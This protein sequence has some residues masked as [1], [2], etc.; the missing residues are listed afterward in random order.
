MV[1]WRGPA[2]TNILP[3]LAEVNTVYSKHYSALE[4]LRAKFLKH[5]WVDA[6]QLI[7]ERIA[8]LEVLDR[9]RRPAAEDVRRHYEEMA[10]SVVPCTQGAGTR[11]F[12]AGVHAGAGAGA[13]AGSGEGASART[14]LRHDAG[15]CPPRSIELLAFR[16]T[17]PRIAYGFASD[18]PLC[19]DAADAEL[20][21]LQRVHQEGTALL[22]K[23]MAASVYLA[24]DTRQFLHRRL[25]ELVSAWRPLLLPANHEGGDHPPAETSYLTPSDRQETFHS[26][27]LLTMTLARQLK[28]G[29]G[30]ETMQK[31]QHAN[32][33]WNI[34]SEMCLLA[35]R[36][37]AARFEFE[38]ARRAL[39]QARKFPLGPPSRGEVSYVET[40]VKEVIARSKSAIR[41]C[42]WVGPVVWARTT[43]V[44]SGDVK[45]AV[46]CCC[47]L[48][49]ELDAFCARGSHLVR[50]IHDRSTSSR[51]CKWVP[52]TV[53]AS[54]Q[55]VDEW[56]N[57]VK[58]ELTTAWKRQGHRESDLPQ[59]A[60]IPPLA[61]TGNN[62]EQMEN[63]ARAMFGDDPA[64][65]AALFKRATAWRCDVSCIQM[66]R[67]LA[68][69]HDGELAAAQAALTDAQEAARGLP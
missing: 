27:Q 30:R 37:H 56:A 57:A 14:R 32:A 9:R 47:E 35:C 26:T 64:H 51:G 4:A 1:S 59:E 38:V 36:H 65:C 3:T 28:R 7:D 55:L 33:K 2:T 11:E 63:E 24:H 44:P 29:F 68:F 54:L 53:C 67:L 21:Y 50:S 60:L 58:A 31:L 34:T 6:L 19:P 22:D 13:G 20:G 41:K 5:L 15:Y 49:K 12:G 66:H 52:V 39:D 62:F 16:G 48:V 10:S 18:T 45:R 40:K 43:D 25:V 46:A 17:G 69:A 61:P 23:A 42:G 8:A